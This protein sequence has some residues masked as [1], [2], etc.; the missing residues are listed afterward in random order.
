MKFISYLVCALLMVSAVGSEARA[1][2]TTLITAATGALGEAI[3]TELAA[4]GH[5]LVLAGRN[6]EKLQKLQEKIKQQYPNSVIQTLVVDFSDLQTLQNLDQSSLPAL[7]GVVLIGP[8]PDL[9]HQGIPSIAQWQKAFQETFIAPLETLRS[10]T[11]NLKA[12]G[13]IVVISGVTSKIH[14]P[15][16]LN[17]NVIRLA[18]TGE[19]KNLVN[20]LANQNI[21]VNAVSP[22]PILTPHHHK[23]LQDKAAAG[24]R[25]FEEQLALE[26]AAIP[27]GEYG[28]TEDVAQLVSFLL[29]AQAKHINGANIVL[30]GGAHPAY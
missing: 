29:S 26:S 1:R 8:R 20:V 6:S 10:L 18:W 17:S 14:M 4:Q 23:R 16:Y 19:V 25:S 3:S 9:P 30:D 15:G 24:G 7:E 13:S 22:G 27:S 21:R 5:D 28:K 11:P 2:S 12:K